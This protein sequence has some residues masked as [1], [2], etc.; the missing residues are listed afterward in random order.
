MITLQTLETI[1]GMAATEDDCTHYEFVRWKESI[2]II[3]YVKLDTGR[4]AS[5]HW[6]RADTTEV[7]I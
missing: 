2:A 3:R 1:F 5:P 4:Y 6:Y 7:L